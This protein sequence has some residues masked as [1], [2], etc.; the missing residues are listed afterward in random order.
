[1][2]NTKSYRYLD[3][4]AGSGLVCEGMRPAF[5]AVWANDICP[6]KS[7]VYRANQDFSVFQLGD[8][9][10][11]RGADLPNA[12][13][14]WASFPCQDLSLA[15]KLGGL[16]GERSGLVWQWLRV[17]KEMKSRP[18][19]FVL[20]NVTG[21]VSAEKGAIYRS[22]HNELASL[23]FKIGPMILNAE[24]WLPQSRPRIFIVAV[25]QD[26]DTSDVQVAK[27]SWIHTKALLKAVDGL[28]KLIFWDLPEPQK[29]SDHLLDLLEK[30]APLDNSST[31][32]RNIALIPE[33]HKKKLFL[34]SKNGFYAAPGYKRIRN[35]KQVLELRFDGVAGCLRFPK[36]GSSR[37]LIVVND[38][39]QLHTRL[40][41]IKE[42]AALMGA[43][44]YRLPGG[45]NE[46]YAAMGDAVAVPVVR[47]LAKHLL[48]KLAVRAYG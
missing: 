3:F 38:N 39:G 45:Y 47:Y 25:R 29:R 4:F 14:S 6:K 28:E 33:R 9:K 34:N 22:L 8:I 10:Q 12:E 48:K 43:P 19:I 44:N 20:E 2:Q 41:T 18:G 31:S 40:L 11:I 24:H 26:I 30:N 5:S 37:Q 46:G 27:P 7:E 21:L 16:K 1:M 23:G 17:M 42:V 32:S 15:G 13:L 36:G 35:K